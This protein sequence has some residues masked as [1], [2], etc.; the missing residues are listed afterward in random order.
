MVDKRFKPRS[1]RPS[2]NGNLRAQTLGSSLD[3][4]LK[5]THPSRT[6]IIMKQHPLCSMSRQISRHLV[7]PLAWISSLSWPILPL[8]TVVK[9]RLPCPKFRCIYLYKNNSKHTFAWTCRL[10][11]LTLHVWR[12]WC[13]RALYTPHT[14]RSPGIWSTPSPELGV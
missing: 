11:N 10:N 12:L 8:H 2:Q 9:C 5:L 3:W 6:E 7:W 13:I 4:Q 1:T 14:D